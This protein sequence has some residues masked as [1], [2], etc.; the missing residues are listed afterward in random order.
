MIEILSKYPLQVAIIAVVCAFIG[1]LLR[2]K[3]A[4]V[5]AAPVSEKGQDRG[6]NLEAALEK[7]KAT[8]KALK[9]EL[10]SLQAATVS[11]TTYETATAELETLRQALDTATK[12]IAPLEAD[13]KKSQ[14]TL[15]TLNARTNEADKAQKDRSFAL[16]NEL[17]KTREQLAILQN[18][19]DDSA[20]LN[21]EIER[22]RESV[23]ASTRYAGEMRKR[24]AAAIEAL[25]KAEAKLSTPSDGPRPAAA[26]EKI[27]PVE[28]SGRIAAAKAEVI[29]LVEMNRLKEEAAASQEAPVVAGK[30]P[31]ITGETP[32]TVEELPVLAEEEPAITEETPV[33]AEEPPIIA[34]KV[35]VAKK[36]PTTGELFSLD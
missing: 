9:A 2:G 12:R 16:E 10:E 30:T 32:A 8:H 36:T 29:R 34:D 24:E 28:D 35:P 18:R 27:G 15:K 11:K 5:K 17:S 7:S 20:A 23:A 1:W 33:I 31:D 6:K 19:P 25:E 13:L 22:L 3:P 4:P 26:S 21:A 14:D